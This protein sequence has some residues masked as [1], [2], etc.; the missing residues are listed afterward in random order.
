MEDKMFRKALKEVYGIEQA[1]SQAENQ[2]NQE[3][4]KGTDKSRKAPHA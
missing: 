3:K 2:D 4:R 1:E